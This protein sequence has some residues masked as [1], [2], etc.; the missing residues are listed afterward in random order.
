MKGKILVMVVASTL[1]YAGVAWAS[2]ALVSNTRHNL[3]PAGPGTIE[4]AA[5]TTDQVCIYCHTPHHGNAVLRPMWNKPSPAETP[6]TA[7]GTTIGGTPTPTTYGALGGITRACLSCHDGVGAVNSLLNM[8]GPGGVTTTGTLV[9]FVGPDANAALAGVQLGPPG[10]L[11]RDMRDDHPVSV[12]YDDSPPRVA[13]LRATTTTINW[14][15]ATTIA[16]LLRDGR[17]ECSSCHDPHNNTHT[18]FLRRSN[19]G[20][21]M[22]IDCHA[23]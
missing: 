21:A 6:F 1:L 16:G 19:A 14:I 15:G 11:G 7:Y 17:V 5:G 20:S 2:T 23:K 12:V 18:L 3:T 9:T 4:G 13:G 22:C 8:P 10:G